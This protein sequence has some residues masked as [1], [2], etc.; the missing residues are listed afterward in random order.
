M[1]KIFLPIAVFCLLTIISVPFL[2]KAQGIVPCD[3]NCGIS[4]FFTLL[5][6]IYNFIVLQIA[7]PLAVIAIVIGAILMMISA[8]NPG[9]FAKGK[10]IIIWSLVG[11][12]LVFCSWL[13]IDFIMKSLGYTGNWS[14][15]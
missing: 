5:V 9:E 6:N 2:T 13:I 3:T 10:E 11:L 8:G 1:K 15:L 12:V 4:D 7:T 14:S